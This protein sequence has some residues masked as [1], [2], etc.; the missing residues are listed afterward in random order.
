[1]SREQMESV[2][3]NCE[4]FCG[5][6]DRQP[7]FYLT[8]GDPILH[9]DFWWLMELFKQKQISFTIMG[10]PFHLTEEVCRHLKECGCVRYQ[11]SLDGLEETHDWFRKPGSYKTTLDKVAILNASGIRSIL[12]TTVSGKNIDEVPQMIDAAVA[13]GAKVYAFARYCPTS[14]DKDTDITP[15][16][17]RRL[18]AECD[19]KFRAYEKD[20]CE[21]YFNRKDHL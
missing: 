12:M 21:T 11:M 8:G 3:K 4:D 14:E 7:Y 15:E 13:A 17:Y 16:R 5:T 18:L 1:M 2:L 9:P 6:F 20:G 19:R 10:N